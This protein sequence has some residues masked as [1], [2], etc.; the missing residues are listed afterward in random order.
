M[1]WFNEFKYI[2]RPKVF[3]SNPTLGYNICFTKIYFE[4]LKI[5]IILVQ[6]AF[7]L[8]Y[9]PEIQNTLFLQLKKNIKKFSVQ[10]NKFYID[11]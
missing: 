10:K 1:A 8:I 2:H 3:G 7:S 4:I 9:M 5:H 6:H 11:K